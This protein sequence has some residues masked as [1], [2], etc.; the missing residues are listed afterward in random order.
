MR[1]NPL[2]LFKPPVA[3]DGYLYSLL[4]L[5]GVASLLGEYD[6]AILNLALP[7]IQNSFQ[8]PDDEMGTMS[9][10]IR[11]GI[12][13]AFLLAMLADRWGRKPLLMIT[14]L[15]FTL[16]TVATAFT[17][18]VEQFIVVQFLT[19]TFLG[20][21]TA[22]AIVLLIEEV[23]A[24][25]RGWAL[26]I[27]TAMIAV[28]QGLASV[29]YAAVEQLPLGWRGAYLV[30]LLPLLLLI[31]AR[32]GIRETKAFAP[33]K[34]TE[35]PFAPLLEV[36]NQQRTAFLLLV[37]ALLLTYT[38][39]IA[40][41]TFTSHSLQRDHNYS[42]G[43]VSSLFIAGGLFILLANLLGGQLSD[44]YGRR[45]V[46]ICGLVLGNLSI[47]GFYQ[48]SGLVVP[49]LW[50]LIYIGY[51]LV[52]LM[53][54]AYA[55]ELFATSRRATASGLRA[56]LIALGGGIGLLIESYFYPVF[57]SH[58]QVL[59]LMLILTIP[60]PFL[61]YWKFPE[62]SQKPLD[63]PLQEAPQEPIDPPLSSPSKSGPS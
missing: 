50:T 36:F 2:P 57:N 17:Q 62:T 12:V 47:L 23:P 31:Y 16:C 6:F 46:L 21:E 20:A 34:S 44:R 26:G 52:D 33:P 1:L 48:C 27:L 53:F 25:A 5:L 43:E 40:G 9:G 58:S 55:A 45:V 60:V 4:L 54:A 7:Q 56:T 37:V 22:L 19:R 11:F 30:G 39:A 38:A 63:E 32:R 13:P 29:I 24:T 42:P 35:S 8:L 51:A 15:G 61:V 59:S 18:T 14:I 41:F 28:G 10:L 3:I 49:L